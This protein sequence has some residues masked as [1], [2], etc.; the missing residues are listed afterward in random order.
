MRE[1]GGRPVL[2]AH[3]LL[4]ADERVALLRRADT[5]VASG[6]WAPPGGHVECGETP[7][8]AAARELAEEMGV[9]LAP[10]RLQPLAAMAFRAGSGGVNFLFR[11]RLSEPLPLRVVVPQADAADWFPLG[12]L[13]RPAVPW[14]QPAL[15]DGPWY[16]D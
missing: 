3:V 9:E 14:L 7:R 4:L 1:Q 13:P 10:A 15:A 16:R 12:R 5:A 6:C 2:V 8:E 11:V